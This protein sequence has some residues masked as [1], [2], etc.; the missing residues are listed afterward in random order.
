M[1][2]ITRSLLVGVCFFALIVFSGGGSHGRSAV[3]SGGVE[4]GR[5]VAAS[6][7]FERSEAAFGFEKG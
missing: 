5:L 2:T 7:G 3:Q 4:H 1:N 6:G